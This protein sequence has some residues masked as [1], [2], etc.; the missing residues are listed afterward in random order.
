MLN[1]PLRPPAV[2][3]RA[4]ASLDI[5][6]G[7]RAELG[8]GAGAFWDGIEAM[9]GDRLGPGQSVDALEEA[10]DVI[11]EL[12]RTD[13]P[14]G[15]RYEGTLL[16]AEGGLPRPAPLHDV[17]HLGRRAQTAHARPRRAQG[18]RLA[19]EHALPAA[20]RSRAQATSASTPARGRSAATRAEIR[21]LLNVAGL[22]GAPPDWVPE[23][24]R[25]ALED[26]V[27]VFILMADD[28]PDDRAARHGGRPDRARAGGGGARR[29]AALAGA[30]RVRSETRARA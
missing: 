26:G 4:V 1:L 8:L 30:G 14:G 7:G 21:R 17:E 25:L 28:P 16:L 29:C 12:W 5:L 24:T 6:S 2:V 10:I 11:R 20:R 15:A 27:S 22:D 23:L 13:E 19:A 3:A 9:G 18:R